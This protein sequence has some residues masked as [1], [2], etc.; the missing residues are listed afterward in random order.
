MNISNLFKESLVYPIKN[1]AK[2]FIVGVLA[3]FIIPNL[4]F[5][6]PYFDPFILNS[7][8]IDNFQKYFELRI[9]LF[10]VSFLISVFIL[11]YGFSIIK[12]TIDNVNNSAKCHDFNIKTNWIDGLKVLII[13]LVYFL[14]PF[15][16][17]I[18]IYS[19]LFLNFDYIGFVSTLILN[20]SSI[21]VAGAFSSFILFNITLMFN[22]VFIVNVI[23]P[24]IIIIFSLF[25]LIAIARFADTKDFKSSFNLNEIIS[26]IKNIGWRKYLVFI[27]CLYL[28]YFAINFI[29]NFVF[30]L[31]LHL[32]LCLVLIYLILYPYLIFVSSRAVGLIYNESKI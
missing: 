19:V 12:S 21:L 20:S 8:I 32:F 31:P 11:G 18:L 17:L 23:I 27:I 16:A 10:V 15:L 6:L 7:P 28:I 13:N 5:N 4:F 30:A 29:M 2:F 3:L 25:Q 24:F 14:I 26:V 1:W 22:L 9:L